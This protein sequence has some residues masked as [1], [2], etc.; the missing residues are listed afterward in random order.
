MIHLVVNTA[1]KRREQKINWNSMWI[2]WVAILLAIGGTSLVGF[3]LEPKA[4]LAWAQ[5]GMVTC[6]TLLLV[7]LVPVL[8]Y[9]KHPRKEHDDES[10]Y[11][12]VGMCCV[13]VICLLLNLIS[14]ATA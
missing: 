8:G 2:A 11:L 3:W 1:S 6:A 13:A 14:Y 7:F 5:G 4:A 9:A 12:N 10:L